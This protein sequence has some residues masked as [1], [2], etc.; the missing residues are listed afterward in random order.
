MQLRAL[1]C[2]TLKFYGLTYMADGIIKM[3]GA[4]FGLLIERWWGEGVQYRNVFHL[5]Y[6]PEAAGK[7]AVGFVRA[8]QDVIPPG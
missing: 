1:N 4:E 2:D 7:G 5:L 8:Y 3:D 6:R